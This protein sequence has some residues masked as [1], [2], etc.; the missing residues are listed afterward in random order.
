MNLLL[1][2]R[3]GD[4]FTGAEIQI[5]NYILKNQEKIPAMSIY[6]LASKTDCSPATVVRLC[7]KLGISGFKEF[8]IK[9]ISEIET[10]KNRNIEVMADS[11][12]QKNDSASEVI[13]KITT[14]SLRSIEETRLL[15]DEDALNTCADLI[16]RASVLD[17]YGVGD[18][19]SIVFDAVQKYISIGK[20]AVAYQAIEKQRIQAL[21]SGEGHL[22]IVVSY[23]GETSEIVEIARTLKENGCPFISVTGNTANTVSKLTK[24]NLFVS[25]SESTYRKGTLVSRNSMLYEF[26]ILFNIVITRDH[27]RFIQNLLKNRVPQKGD[28]KNKSFQM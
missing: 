5:R 9:L 3:E 8:K 28:S 1:R 10:M 23:T 22:G 17:F 7:R 12:V 26:D 2:M 14:L 4:E 20:T 13:Q 25:G 6:E 15:L 24:Y 27:D 18:S 11:L 16:Y 21:N 19:N